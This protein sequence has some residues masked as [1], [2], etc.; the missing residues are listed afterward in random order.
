MLINLQP[1]YTSDWSV[2]TRHS[3]C[4]A[5]DI[6][7]AELFNPVRHE[8]SFQLC[9]QFFRGSC[10]ILEMP[11]NAITVA[12]HFVIQCENLQHAIE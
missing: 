11:Y 6:G 3:A 10:F 5:G 12:S 1:L 4:Y 8:T 2:R 9:L 7:L